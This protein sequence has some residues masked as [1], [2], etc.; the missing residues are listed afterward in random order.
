M[1][2]NESGYNNEIH[3]LEMPVNH[4]NSNRMH[5]YETLINLGL[6]LSYFFRHVSVDWM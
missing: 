4:T 3:T 6:K 1:T 5:K 2:I